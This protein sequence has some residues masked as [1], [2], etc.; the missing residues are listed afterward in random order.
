MQHDDNVGT[1][2]QRPIV[3]GLLIAAV[4]LVP[5]MYE[6]FLDSEATGL[7]HGIVFAAIIGENDF[8]DYIKRYLVVGLL[9]CLFGIVGRHHNNDF[10][11]SYHTKQYFYEA[12]LYKYPDFSNQ[13][14]I[15][16]D[17]RF[18]LFCGAERKTEIST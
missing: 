2:F 11:A 17:Q 3:A 16:E 12:K 9:Q 6:N 13:L 14:H 10:L 15:L 18:F 5:F 7:L 1:Q 8:I 4:P